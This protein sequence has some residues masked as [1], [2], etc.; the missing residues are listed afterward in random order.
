MHDI[1]NAPK[2]GPTGNADFTRRP[3][4]ALSTVINSERRGSHVRDSVA[5][6]E[7][8]RLIE[9]ARQ[10]DQVAWR[11]IIELHHRLVWWMLG[12]YSFDHATQEDIYQTVWCRLAENL[13]KIRD[14]ERLPAWMATT[15][16]NEALKR[17]RYEKRIRP[18]DLT[19]FELIA[20]DP[21]PEETATLDDQRRSVLDAFARLDELCRELL[22]L[23][24]TDPPLGYEEI[25]EVWGRPIGSIGPT[26]ARCLNQLRKLIQ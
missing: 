26:R 3:G 19:D 7:R 18:T 10:G 22:V 13:D 8:T 21:T 1:A 9:A 14:P 6:G 24:T 20:D 23:C 25:A 15:T 5:A 12:S 2:P 16:R 17:I 11:S 4:A